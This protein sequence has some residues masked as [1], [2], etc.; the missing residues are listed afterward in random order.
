MMATA[1]ANTSDKS[2]D[3]ESAGRFAALALDCVDQEYPNLIHHVM[4][5]DDDVGAPRELTPTFYGC[6]DWHSSVHG[7]WLLVRLARL[8]PEA[9]FADEARDKLAANLTENNLLAEA[10]YMAHPDRTGFERPYG[11]AWLLQLIT[12][13]DQWDDEQADDWREW[14]RPVEEIA[15]RRLTDWIPKLHYPIRIGEHDQTAFAFG[16]S[17][18]YARQVD[19]DELAS[20]VEEAAEQFYAGDRDCPLHY[21]PSGHDFLSP[22]LAEADLMRRVMDSKQFAGW[23]D[24]FMPGIGEDN[25]LPVAVVTDRADGKLSH[26]DGLNLSRAWML[27]GIVAGLPEGDSRRG[28]LEASAREHTEAGLSGVS[29][30]HYAGG[31]WLASFAVY[32]LSRRGLSE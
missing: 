13:L 6:Y 8:F 15:V 32:L 29:D 18:D 21:E 19:N 1:D 9:G 23:L 24:T 27:E 5:G 11:L 28:A 16:L 7:H 10:A 17:L 22:C 20:V 12:E 30:E 31:H 2:L 4:A 25:W 3:A 14:L 26:I